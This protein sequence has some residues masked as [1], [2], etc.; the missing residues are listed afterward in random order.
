[1]LNEPGDFEF[2]LLFESEQREELTGIEVGRFREESADIRFLLDGVDVFRT[3]WEDLVRLLESRGHDVVESAS[4]YDEV[5]T[6]GLR[7]ANNNSFEH[8]SSRSPLLRAL[9]HISQP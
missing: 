8:R 7:L 4:G 3:P 6:L 1:M 2:V 5:P 9:Y